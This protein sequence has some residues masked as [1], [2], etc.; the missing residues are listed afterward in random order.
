MFKTNVVSLII[1]ICTQDKIEDFYTMEI[2]RDLLKHSQNFPE[3]TKA[4]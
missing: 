4:Q 3:K 2:S 1:S